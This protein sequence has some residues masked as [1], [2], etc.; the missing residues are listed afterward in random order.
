MIHSKIGFQAKFQL[1]IFITFAILITVI[2]GALAVSVYK[3][4]SDNMIREAESSMMQVGEKASQQIDSMLQT[5]DSVA[6][7][8]VCNPSIQTIFENI[9]VSDTSSQNYFEQYPS[10]KNETCSMLFSI[11]SPALL[12]KRISVFNMYGDF[13]NSGVLDEQAYSGSN[14]VHSEE[15]QALFDTFS[16]PL[17]F[18]RI[19]TPHADHWNGK[20]TNALISIYRPVKSLKSHNIYAIVEVQQP[21]SLFADIFSSLSDM[22]AYVF[23]SEGE[24]IYPADNTEAEMVSFFREETIGKAASFFQ[25]ENP[26]TNESELVT[27]HQSTYSG[28]RVVLV[29]SRSTLISQIRFMGMMFVWFGV[30]LLGILFMVIMILSNHL[31]RPLVQLTKVVQETNLTHM[32]IPLDTQHSADEIAQ[33]NTAFHEMMLRL[34]EAITCEVNA[35]VCA[36]QA[37]MNPHFLYNT[38]A[39][40]SAAAQDIN[41]QQIMDM[42]Q[43][44][45][46]M[47][48]YSS[49]FDNESV[50][51]G[52]EVEYARLYMKLMKIRYE[53]CL[54]Y[55]FNAIP[56]ELTIE[57]PKF[58]LQPLLENCFQHGLSRVDPP[59]YVSV[60][61][62]VTEAEWYITVTDNGSGFQDGVI[63]LI[64]E[65]AEALYANLQNEFNKTHIGNLGL[66]SIY[67]RLKTIYKDDLIFQLE[68][69]APH[70]ARVI[71]GGKNAC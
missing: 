10:Q 41:N 49:A 25:T 69:T 51:L 47:I 65:K 34:K 28:W 3:Y 6:L 46:E 71:I 13:V 43:I 50:T 35:Q 63:S 52:N 21:Y 61:V 55:D 27:C 42:C 20:N 60:A 26:I 37:Q 66:S 62:T 38:I 70:G 23:T 36:L 54:S 9:A 39:V 32:D 44:L 58:I 57:T 33:L 1:K 64:T 4:V 59:W 18:R 16:Q 5:M 17:Q 40:I 56:E 29:Q 68:N 24:C 12:V 22:D 53:D 2:I 48:R 19:S 8:V 31:T 45:S 15:A 67:A 30:L 11:N 7:Q 14:F